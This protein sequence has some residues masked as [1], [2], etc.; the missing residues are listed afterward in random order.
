MLTGLAIVTRVRYLRNLAGLV[1]LTT[2]ASGLLDY[3]FKAAAVAEYVEKAERQRFFAIFYT[4]SALATFLIQALFGSR[5]L[6]RFG[7]GV[8]MGT[9][10]VITPGVQ[11]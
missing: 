11:R 10:P 4:A 2:T 5:V 1:L 7:I 9:L 8:T 3:I 6:N